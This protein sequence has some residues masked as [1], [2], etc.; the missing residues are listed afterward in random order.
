M[1]ALVLNV[2]VMTS[3]PTPQD[4]EAPS[5]IA[6]LFAGEEEPTLTRA[7]L[8]ALIPCLTGTTGL[9]MVTAWG[10][11]IGAAVTGQERA[12]I[13]G[14]PD[15]VRRAAW[16][17][18][19]WGA[20]VALPLGLVTRLLVDGVMFLTATHKAGAAPQ[21]AEVVTL[22]AAAGAFSAIA[23]GALGGVAVVGA[24]QGGLAAGPNLVLGGL[25]GAGIVTLPLIP[26]LTVMLLGRSLIWKFAHSRAA[27]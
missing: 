26:V 9:V 7:F 15:E 2:L 19:G 12:R 22:G 8:T 18:A 5:P 11:V 13:G 21:W 27:T 10:A 3:T 24:T 16:A 20:L 6:F 25:I 23:L 14:S 17:G 4:A 1:L